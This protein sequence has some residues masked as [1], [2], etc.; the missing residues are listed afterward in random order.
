MRLILTLVGK[1]CK[2][3]KLSLVYTKTIFITLIISYLINLYLTYTSQSLFSTLS[4]LF[5][6]TLVY[7]KQIT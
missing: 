4:K 7:H 5:S 1:Y 6:L 2:H 3:F